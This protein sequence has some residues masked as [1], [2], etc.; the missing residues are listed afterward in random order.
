M[1]KLGILSVLVLLT[2]SCFKDVN[3][4]TTIS[5]YK[6]ILVDRK[7]LATTVTFEK[8]TDL[9]KPG[10]ICISSN[11]VFI[12]EPFL[13]VHV[14][15]NSDPSKPVNLGLIRVLGVQNIDIKGNTLFADNATDIIAIDIS[16]PTIPVVKTRLENIIPNPG[17]PDGKTLD[18]PVS[19]AT[20]PANTVVVGWENLK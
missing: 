9:N 19:A 17:I 8:A 4:P 12:T 2:S 5:A 14:F 10:K 3:Q 15:D 1:Q 6:P 11:F 18:D 20:W 13:G 7:T 16:N